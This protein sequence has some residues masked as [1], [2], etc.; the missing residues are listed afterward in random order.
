MNEIEQLINIYF[1]DGIYK[2]ILS[3]PKGKDVKYDKITFTRLPTYIQIEKQFGNQVFHENIQYEDAKNSITSL[4]GTDYNQYNGWDVSHSFSIRINKKGKLLNQKQICAQ[5]PDKKFEHNRTKSYLIQEGTI[6]PPLIDMGIFTA[7]GKV[8][9]SMY[10][11][12]KQINRF[13]ET[14]DDELASWDPNKLLT[15]V[16]F[17]CGKSYLTFILYYYFVFIK[18]LT[19]KMVGLDLKKSVID[20]C[21][22]AA[23]K[24]GY[25]SLTFEVGDINGYASIL[26][27]DLV[28]TLHACDTATD[29]ALYNA[30]KWKAHYVFSVPC[31]QHELN[32]QINSSELTIINRYG[33]IQERISALLTDAI[34]ANLLVCCGYKSQVLEFVDLSHTPKNLLI[35]A[36][37]T[38]IS[39][40]T[41]QK[42]LQEVDALIKEFSINPLLINLLKP[43]LDIL[44]N[45]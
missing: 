11:K 27:V 3:N 36:V 5:S 18:K 9:K 32:L 37:K 33:I 30:V 40:Q 4:L 39:L 8:V 29:Y 34:R 15:V 2:A 38:H 31:C 24:Y 20:T 19:V 22:E 7:D 1:H 16:D 35:R 13:I 28:V 25:Q 42:A 23:A 10:D 12:Y 14:I 17:G 45:S 41:K 26:P 43:T 21:N 6:V 44:R